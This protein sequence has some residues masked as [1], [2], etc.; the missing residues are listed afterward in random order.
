L[1]S[2]QNLDLSVGISYENYFKVQDNREVYPADFKHD[3]GYCMA[4][5]GTLFRIYG[6]PVNSSVRYDHYHVDLYT[7]SDYTG[8]GGGSSTRA[9]ISRSVIGLALYPL[10]IS[11]REKLHF[12][13]GPEVG[14]K[15]HS[16]T[17][18]KK[19]YWMMGQKGHTYHIENDSM[20]INK[21]FFAGISGSAA[22]FF[23]VNE[24]IKISTHLRI[25]YGI[26]DE[27]KNLQSQ[28]R[29]IRFSLEA[30]I[31]GN[32]WRKVLKT[33]NVR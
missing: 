10:N 33:S 24:R 14:F 20:K 18:G 6:Y 23:P 31:A 11:F 16:K 2:G 8:L 22:Y 5:T 32:P 19:A 15:I 25:Y 28:L 12:S 1:A 7:G 27:F 3:I 13:V 17:D 4:I 29:M 9:D 21:E 26:T 30:G